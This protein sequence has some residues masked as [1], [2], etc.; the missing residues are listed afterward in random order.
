MDRSKLP[1][2]IVSKLDGY[3]WIKL[4]SLSENE[5]IRMIITISKNYTNLESQLEANGF[6]VITRF[7]NK[8]LMIG[9]VRDIFRLGCNLEFIE[10]IE[11][12]NSMG[13]AGLEIE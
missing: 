8:I 6:K 1:K 13:Q 7:E 4:P 2:E 12:S 9:Y 3:T 11:I 5:Q 10:S